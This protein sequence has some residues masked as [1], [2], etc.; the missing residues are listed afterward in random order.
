VTT[1]S[2]EE[3]QLTM[4]EP[5][6]TST[7]M[8]DWVS[9]LDHKRI[10]IM[11]ILTA[12]FY[13]AVGGFEA[14]LMRIQ[15]AFPNNTFLSPEMFN[16]LFTMHG[17][18]MVFLVG[19]PVLTGFANYFVPLMIGARDVAFPRLNSFGF[20]M[21]FF[22]A[23]LLHFSFLTGSAPNAGWFSYVPLSSK[24]YS[25]LQGVDYWIIGLLIMGIGSVSGA[26]NIFATII[27]LRAPGMSLQRVPLF[28]WMM[29]MQAILIILALP[30]LNSALAMLLIDRWLGSAFFDPT[31]GGSAVLWQHYFWI[32]GHPEV[33]ILILPGFGMISEVIPVFSRKPIYGYTFIAASSVAIVLLGYGVWAHHMFAV[34]LGMYAD[35]FF[36]VGSL[37]IAIPTGIKVFNWTA[38]LWGGEIKFNTSLH[39]AI[40][41]LLQ[42][43][44]GGLTGIMFAAVPI[45][46]QLTDTYFVVAHFHYVL[47]G[48]L[49]FALFSAAYYWFPKMTGRMLNER[50][51]ILQFWLWVLG[52]NMTFMVQHFL[53]MMGMPRRVY[54][55]AD[56]PGWALLNGIATLGA[57]F[58]AVGTLVFLWN[59]FKSLHSGKIAGDNPWDAFTLEWATTSPPPPEN[60]PVI[61]EVK[62]RRPVW[63]INHP[64]YADWKKEKTPEDK[65][66]RGNLAKI[67]AWSFIASEAVFFLLLLVAYVVFNTKLMAPVGEASSPETLSDVTSSVLDVKRT[68]IFSLFLITS[69]LTFWVA[70]RFLKAGKKSAFVFSL[71]L[72][73]LL[74]I[75]FLGG[76][77]WEYTGLLSNGISINSDLFSATFFTVTGFHGIHVTAGVIA[78]FV[79]LLMGLKGNLSSEKTHVF[80]AVGVYWHFVDVVWIAVFGI[81]YLGLLQ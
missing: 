8:L 11:Y 68:G 35:I 2:V 72:T 5:Q 52:F 10:G 27:N 20:W 65:G 15:L 71:G 67:A 49:V 3:S 58:M 31:R 69:S 4:L 56:N 44:I 54:T 21:F 46:W 55:Y 80:G 53:G 79:M 42:F 24:A 50:I 25:S 57:V 29:L 73:I 60:F 28:V 12:V 76:Q 45:D 40:A 33:Y 51:G 75:I 74:G 18:T 19:M 43:V 37:L 66:R 26:I 38:T 78:L 13:L 77:V 81:I 23:A 30:A 9:T 6:P 7:R 32:F 62:S 63:D 48:G 14:L 36:A 47:I 41:F 1:G 17:T 34:G 16:Q 22:G 39:F 61:P 70:E 59:I 64:E